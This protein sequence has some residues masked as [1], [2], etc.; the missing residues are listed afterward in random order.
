MNVDFDWDRFEAEG[1]DIARRMREVSRTMSERNA[2]SKA[3][4]ARYEDRIAN[5]DSVARETPPSNGTGGV[6][7]RMDRFEHALAG[8]TQELAHLR[9]DVSDIRERMATKVELEAVHDSVKIVADGYAQTQS[10][11]AEVSSLL[12]RYLTPAE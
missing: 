4:R 6:E 1:E 8:I 2:A 9:R 11:L 5:G 7:T 12:K 10:R 3:A